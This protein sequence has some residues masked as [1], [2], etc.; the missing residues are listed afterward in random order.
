MT[1]PIYPGRQLLRGLTYNS[2]WSPTFFNQSATTTTGADLDVGLAQYPLHDFELTYRFLRDGVHWQDALEGLEF[3]TMM[4]FHL[5]M[6]GT[7]GRCRYLNP[8]DYRVFQQHLGIGDGVKTTFTLVRTFG[9]N[10]FFGTEPVGQV[11]IDAGVNVYLDGSAAP[12]DPALY[13]ISTAVPVANTITFASAPAAGHAI[14]V[15]MQ[16]YYY[17]KL[18]Q[19]NNTFEKFMDRVWMLSKVT[20][21]GCRAGA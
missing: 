11:D 5:A 19:D 3:K 16:Y 7:L 15:D 2:K 8:D 1:L 6:A 13:T 18:A 4:G 17:C 21:H 9:A 14:A 20:L 10:G 12:L